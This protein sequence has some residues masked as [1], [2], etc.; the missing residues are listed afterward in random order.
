MEGKGASY[1]TAAVS[2]LGTM[3]LVSF[4]SGH[5]PIRSCALYYRNI[6]IFPFA[7][8]NLVRHC[9]NG[10]DEPRAAGQAQAFSLPNRISKE[11]SVS[12]KRLSVEGDDLSV[13][14]F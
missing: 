8:D 14:H 9:V 6:Q 12:T 7:Y 1:G 2:K 10:D 4:W 11:P 13:G 3:R 5:E